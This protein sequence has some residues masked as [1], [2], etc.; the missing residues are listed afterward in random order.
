MLVRF[1]LAGFVSA[2][3]L[4]WPQWYFIK[5][6]IIHAMYNTYVCIP[7]G[8]TFTVKSTK[9]QIKIKRKSRRI[10]RILLTFIFFFFSCKSFL[11]ERKSFPFY[12]ESWIFLSRHVQNRC[13]M[14]VCYNETRVSMQDGMIF[15]FIITIYI[16]SLVCY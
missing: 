9:M 10:P 4:I 8:Y 15:W 14:R 16:R 5:S 13:F 3:I 1:I 7:I 2:I 12:S 6:A 11:F